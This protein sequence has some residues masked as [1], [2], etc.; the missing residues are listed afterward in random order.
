[1]S[2]S[3]LSVGM[4]GCVVMGAAPLCQTAWGEVGSGVFESC[5]SLV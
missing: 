3:L 1:V 4:L 5:V 2:L